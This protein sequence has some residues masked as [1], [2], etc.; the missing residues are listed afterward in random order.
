VYRSEIF[1]PTT[2]QTQ[3][4]ERIQY[5]VTEIPSHVA[6]PF[7]T[8]VGRRKNYG[9]E[10]LTFLI[11]AYYVFWTTDQLFLVASKSHNIKSIL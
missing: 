9:S 1:W 11:N 8:T 6:V 7:D 3:H 10:A 4:C 5:C 2:N